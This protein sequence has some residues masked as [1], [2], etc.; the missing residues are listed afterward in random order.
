[1]NKLIQFILKLSNYT[2]TDTAYNELDVF[3]F[4][5]LFK[6]NVLLLIYINIEIVCQYV[7]IMLTLNL[8]KM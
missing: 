4:E 2:S 3:N 7:A 1:M 6:K 8:R 5:K